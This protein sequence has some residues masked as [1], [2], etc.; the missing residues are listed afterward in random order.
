[1]ATTGLLPL[2]EE[3][4]HIGDQVLDLRK[5]AQGCDGQSPIARD[6]GD[7]SATGPAGPAVDRHGTRAAHPDPAR[8]AVGEPRLAVTLHPSD[9]VQHGLVVAVRHLEALEMTIFSTAPDVDLELF[10]RR[11]LQIFAWWPDD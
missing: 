6:F 11:H 4:G 9:N 7:M 2:L 1:V 5:I 8:E 3:A 10:V